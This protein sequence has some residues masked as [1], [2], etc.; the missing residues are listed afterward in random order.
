MYRFVEVG[1]QRGR[2]DWTSPGWP[3]ADS[4][5]NLV[6][7]TISANDTSAVLESVTTG[8]GFDE[9]VMFGPD[10]YLT[11]PVIVKL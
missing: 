6:P 5:G 3:L 1:A 2:L 8:P 7:H 9:R 10:S 11:T 4:V